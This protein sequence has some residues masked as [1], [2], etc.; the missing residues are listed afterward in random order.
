MS[1]KG[2]LKSSKIYINKLPT[3]IQEDEIRDE[4]KKYGDIKDIN[5]KRGFCFLEY[6][7]KSQAEK[8]IEEMDGV[9]F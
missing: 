7:S 8:A 1:R 9:K 5:L 6:E 3:N 2:E 4:F